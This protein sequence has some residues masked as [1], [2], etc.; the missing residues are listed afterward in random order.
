ML[1][2]APSSLTATGAPLFAW[3]A[4]ARIVL[5]MIL[6]ASVHQAMAE[7][8]HGDRGGDR[9]SRGGG[10]HDFRSFDERLPWQRRISN[11]DQ[12]IEPDFQN[13]PSKQPGNGET[14]AKRE[15]KSDARPEV[16]PEPRYSSTP[17]PAVNAPAPGS[18]R[19]T[20]AEK[21]NLRQS[22]QD[23]GREVYRPKP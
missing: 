9:G 20:D 5:G 15:Q 7:P 23:A 22:I 1:F 13:A 4:L 16:R 11:R 17:G 18:G 14:P 2:R 10:M 3:S 12:D 6:G 19:L 8:G 21:R